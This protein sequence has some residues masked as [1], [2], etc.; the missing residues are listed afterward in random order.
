[1][2][3]AGVVATPAL[4]TAAGGGVVLG[5]KSFAFKGAGWG[6]E[7]PAKIFNGGDPSGLVTQIHWKHWGE[8]V[9][10]GQ[11]RNSI[12]KPKGG[13]YPHQVTIKLRASVIGTCGGR[14][15]YTRLYASEPSRPGGPFGPWRLWSGAKS[16]CSPR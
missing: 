11:G 1:M 16:I 2:L 8:V 7:K 6:T 4:A 10:L 12:F 15:A 5:S 13:Y 9:A 3:A 14:R